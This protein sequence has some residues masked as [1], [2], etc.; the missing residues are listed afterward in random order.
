MDS[1]LN[2]LSKDL[3]KVIESNVLPSYL[4]LVEFN[5]IVGNSQC[6]EIRIHLCLDKIKTDADP[7]QKFYE[8]FITMDPNSLTQFFDLCEMIKELDDK[9]P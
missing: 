2:Y 3:S 6:D 9:V 1:V 8:F 4:T 7:Y 5:T